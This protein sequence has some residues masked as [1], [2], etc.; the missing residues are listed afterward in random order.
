M[1]ADGARLYGRCV[2]KLSQPLSLEDENIFQISATVVVL[3][4]SIQNLCRITTTV[5][6]VWKMCLFSRY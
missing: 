6:D 5:A 4:F 2:P 3:N 1:H